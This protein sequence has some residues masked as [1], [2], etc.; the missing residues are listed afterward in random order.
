MFDLT[1]AKSNLQIYMN[2]FFNDL[3]LRLIVYIMVHNI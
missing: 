3:Y 2:K 1:D